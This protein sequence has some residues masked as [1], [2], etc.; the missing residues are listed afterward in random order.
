MFQTV[1]VRSIIRV[2]MRVIIR[3]VIWGWN[4]I[5]GSSVRPTLRLVH[6]AVQSGQ[7]LSRCRAR[8]I[9]A[10][11]GIDD[12]AVDAV[13]S[14]VVVGEGRRNEGE[15]GG[16]HEYQRYIRGCKGGRI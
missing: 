1:I 3:V 8:D 10:P 13:D 6:D 15:K 7:E 9:I 14:Y 5:T 4:R 11:G 2:I 16:K 12:R